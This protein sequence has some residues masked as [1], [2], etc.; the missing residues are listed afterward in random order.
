MIHTVVIFA[1]VLSA[2]NWVLFLAVV[3][4]S[5]ITMIPLS[6]KEE[7]KDETFQV[8]QAPLDK[9]IDSTGTLATSF[10]IAGPGSS[11][12]AMSLVC[13]LIAAVAAGIDRF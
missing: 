12:A 2:A 4:V 5:N 1:L 8:R 3:V 11:A 7:G 9:L 13:L 6:P 10:N